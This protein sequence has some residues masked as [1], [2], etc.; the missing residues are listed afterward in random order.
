MTTHTVSDSALFSEPTS[1][2]FCDRSTLRLRPVDPSGRGSVAR[3]RLGPKPGARVRLSQKSRPRAKP[4][5]DLEPPSHAGAP[6]GRLKPATMPAPAISDRTG[7]TGRSLGRCAFTPLRPLARRRTSGRSH[8]P[9][10]SAGEARKL[11]FDARPHRRAEAHLLD[12]GA[13]DARRLGPADCADEGAHILED[14]RLR[15]ARLA[16][17][18]LND[19]RLLRAELDL[20]AL[21]HRAGNS[22][23]ARRRPSPGDAAPRALP[24]F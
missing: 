19:A 7:M 17:A 5:R 16:D 3:G 23:R 6:R 14:R 24:D 15:E 9:R 18:G 4:V 1:F 10:R 12:E 20:A 22:R 11:Q 2:S 8:E 13:L 21:G